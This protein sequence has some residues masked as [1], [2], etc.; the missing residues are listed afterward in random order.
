MGDIR[1]NV[2]GERSA[3]TLIE[4][5][6]VVAII[7]LLISILLPSLSRAKKQ[8]RQIVC[9]TNLREQG[10][11]AY[12]YGEDN[13][14][15]FGRGIQFEGASSLIGAHIYATTVLQGL[16][17][18]NSHGPPTS[19]WR[20]N[21]ST[22][23]NPAF[24]Q[25]KRMRRVFRQIGQF[26]CPDYPSEAHRPAERETSGY[27]NGA[28]NPDASN[29][30]PVTDQWLDY[31]A[32]A[33]PVPYTDK[34]LAFDA[35]LAGP[36]GDDFRSVQG[37]Q[38]DYSETEQLDRIANAKN[39]AEVAYVTEAQVSL[40]WNDFTFHHFFIGAQ[41]PFGA[42]PRIANDMRHPGGIAVLFFDG[43]AEVTNPAQF[44]LGWDKPLGQ[45]LRWV[46]RVDDP[47]YW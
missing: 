18:D 40:P 36:P 4:L 28:Y 3:F 10:K 9:L 32:S 33:T 44:D 42:F 24:H 12:F 22:P 26:Q 7:A 17:Y 13:R 37:G 27:S 11:A 21:P 30:G 46:T 41:L 39:P 2:A 14:G 6:V 23:G 25:Q 5:L 16:G 43:H 19:L 8:A 20:G 45:R 38:T 31:V 29:Q 47:R 1:R 35:A 15:Y 34:N